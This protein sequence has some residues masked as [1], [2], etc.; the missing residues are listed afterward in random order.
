MRTMRLPILVVTIAFIVSNFLPSIALA[1]KKADLFE[2][3]LP[4]RQPWLRDNL[5]NEASIYVRIPNVYGMLAAPKG[6]SLDSALRSSANVENLAKIKKG[7][8]DNVLPLIP[9]F[10]DARVQLL[11]RYT[12][13]PIEI[14]VFLAASPSIL[15]A[16]NVEL[17]SNDALSDVLASFAPAGPGFGLV[18]PLSERG[19]GQID[20]MGVPMFIQFDAD[21]GRLLL[22]AGPGVSLE[23]FETILQKIVSND[24]HPM[25]RMER[26]IDE[27]GQGFFTWIDAE[28]AMPAMQMFLQPDQFEELLEIGLDKVRSA[29]FGWGV[30]N[31]KGRLAVVA[32]V[33]S[34]GNRL[35]LPYVNNDISARSAGDPDALLVLSIPTADEFSRI[36]A[37]ALESAATETNEKWLD[38]K[39]QFSEMLGASVEEI[40][41]A[42]GPEVL[43][44]FDPVGDYAAIR[45]RDARLW[46]GIV[47]RIAAN[48]SVDLEKKRIRGKNYFHMSWLG[49]FSFLDEETAAEVGW[50]MTLL[51]KQRDHVYWMRDDDF[52]YLASTPQSLIDRDARRPRTNIGKWLSETQRVESDATIFAVTVSHE[53]LPRRFYMVYI[54]LLQV[55][56]EFAEVDI[57]VWAMPTPDQL[58]LSNE[59][60]LSVNVSLGDPI[61][62]MELVFESSPLEAVFTGGVGG[63]AMTGIL[64]AIAVPAYQDYRIR[65]QVSEGLALSG[66]AKAAVSE[67]YDENGQFPNVSAAEQMSIVKDAGKY[68]EAITVIEG[69]GTIVI[70]YKEDALPGDGEVYLEPDVDD[71]GYVYWSCSSTLDNKHLPSA[72]RE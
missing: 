53:K 5:P 48:A 41:A 50:F 62:A 36:E 49:N 70:L 29:A 2:G 34:E 21:S 32:D 59:G 44:V 68:V 7:I 72:C 61:I 3:E 43:F 67:Y 25:R 20:G 66:A 60:A 35:L 23:E 71:Q 28:Q 65:A 42:I 26:T 19:V 33:P 56:A 11:E 31:G 17:D 46:E 10:E 54:E 45:V 52:L 14:A 18:E 47:E 40:L 69:S 6:N 22:N 4:I 58:R 9:L 63:I 13:S 1:Q 38:G 37:F 15:L 8:S 16:M 24:D 51:R 55:L 30:A 27:G 57:D 12:R 64:A 39:R